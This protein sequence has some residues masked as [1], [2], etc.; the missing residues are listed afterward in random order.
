V[1]VAAILDAAT[2]HEAQAMLGRCCA[3]SRWVQGM[4]GHR[5][6]GDDETVHRCADAVW[7]AMDRADVLEALAGHPEIGS[8]LE[9]LREKF[10]HT[11]DWSGQEQSTVADADEA[12]LVALR[13]TNLRYRERFGHIFVVCATGKSAEE[14]LTLL[15]VRIDN[16]PVDE[17]AIAAAEQSKITHL[18]LEKLRAD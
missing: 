5:P 3:A 7:Q 15:R 17:L 16:D 12:T 4:L 13:D 14:M 6:F 9:A 1:S 11:A 10:A 18:R 8:S 2:P